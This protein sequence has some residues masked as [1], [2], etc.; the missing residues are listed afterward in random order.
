MADQKYY[1]RT[2]LLRCMMGPE[3]NIIITMLSGEVIIHTQATGA[4]AKAGGGGGW[5]EEDHSYLKTGNL[6]QVLTWV[7]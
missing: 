5:K 4:A 3:M 6:N 1:R 7:I 2:L